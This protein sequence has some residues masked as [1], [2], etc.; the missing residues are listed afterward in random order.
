LWTDQKIADFVF[1][2]AEHQSDII[3]RINTL[4]G[5]RDNAKRIIPGATRPYDQNESIWDKLINPV[6]RRVGQALEDYENGEPVVSGSENALNNGLD[7]SGPEITINPFNREFW[8]PNDYGALPSERTPRKR[9]TLPYAS[10]GIASVPTE[11]PKPAPETREGGTREGGT[12]EQDT[13]ENAPSRL[14]PKDTTPAPKTNIEDIKA[15][16]KENVALAMIQAGL[17]MA[18]GE[19][20]NALKN[21]AAGGISGIGAFSELEKA[22]RAANLE[23]RKTALQEKYYKDR[24][25]REQATIDQARRRNEIAMLNI[26]REAQASAAKEFETMVKADPQLGLD[27]VRSATVKKQLEDKYLRGLMI[28]NSLGMGSGGAGAPSLNPDATDIFSE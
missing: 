2:E 4:K 10:T 23:E 13:G 11:T 9:E 1:G 22:T 19:S 3:G 20:P 7:V 12:R 17:A 5:I 26:Y 28:N 21:I 18:G 27:P 25:D 14:A 16:R 6:A 15:S 8:S 24:A